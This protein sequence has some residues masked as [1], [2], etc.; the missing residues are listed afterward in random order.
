LSDIYIYISYVKIDNDMIFKSIQCVCDN[1]E[2]ER[3]REKERKRERERER[4]DREDGEGK[5][6]KSHPHYIR[7]LHSL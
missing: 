2:R 1:V 7:F 5:R 4:E 3:K 6:R